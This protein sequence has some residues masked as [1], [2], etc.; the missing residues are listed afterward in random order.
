MEPYKGKRMNVV[1]QVEKAQNVLARAVGGRQFQGL[2]SFPP[3]RGATGRK[4]APRFVD[5][6]ESKL[7]S[8]FPGGRPEGG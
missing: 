6:P 1:V 2:S 5:R 3:G 7:P 8:R 4:R